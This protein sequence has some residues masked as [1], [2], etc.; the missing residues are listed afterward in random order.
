M[1]KLKLILTTISTA[2]AYVFGGMD[3]MLAILIIFMIIDDYK[4]NFYKENLLLIKQNIVS[5]S[6]LKAISI[7]DSEMDGEFIK[8]QIELKNEILVD[9][10]YNF[11]L[12]KLQA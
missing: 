1:E 2:L 9:S 12:R 3:K 7:F 10:F 4:F 5:Q 11:K 6:F 8:D